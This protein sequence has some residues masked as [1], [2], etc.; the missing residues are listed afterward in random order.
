MTRKR[1]SYFFHRFIPCTLVDYF[2]STEPWNS[3]GVL[4]GD[5]VFSL[6]VLNHLF[7]MPP[8]HTPGDIARFGSHSDFISATK[9]TVDWSFILWENKATDAVMVTPFIFEKMHTTHFQF[10][11]KNCLFKFIIIYRTITLKR[12]Y[13]KWEVQMHVYTFLQ[14]IIWQQE[15]FRIRVNIEAQTFLWMHNYVYEIHTTR[16]SFTFTQEYV[17]ITISIVDTYR[18]F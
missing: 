11:N 6:H 18:K 4:Y 13:K 10:E 7:V 2:G 12:S 3:V 8:P 9:Q 16:P 15:I 14:R 1:D 5:R 17:Y